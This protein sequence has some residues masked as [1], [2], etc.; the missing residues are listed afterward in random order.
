MYNE[1][2]DN[3]EKLP[4]TFTYDNQ[5]YRG[6]G[7]EFKEISH[8]IVKEDRKEK[9]IFELSF[10]NSIKVTIETAFYPDYNACEWT[11]YFENTGNM[12]TGIFKNVYS[13]DMVLKEK[14]HY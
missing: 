5:I 3:L 4:V 2:I 12:D 7:S 14:N 11:V 1:Y 9:N 6:F 8:K 10:K 13:A